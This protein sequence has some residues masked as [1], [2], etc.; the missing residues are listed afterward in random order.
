MLL[1]GWFVFAILQELI[2]EYQIEGIQGFRMSCHL[3]GYRCP[4]WA[5]M[6]LRPGPAI[7]QI[8]QMSKWAFGHVNHPKTSCADKVPPVWV[9]GDRFA[10]GGC[11]L[12]AH[13]LGCTFLMLSAYD[14]EELG[15]E[16]AGEVAASIACRLVSGLLSFFLIDLQEICLHALHWE[17]REEYGERFNVKTHHP[18]TDKWTEPYRRKGGCTEMSLEPNV[19]G[20]A[21]SFLRWWK[22]ID[23]RQWHRRGHTWDAACLGQLWSRSEDQARSKSTWTL[24]GDS[25]TP[26]SASW[27]CC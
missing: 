25:P 24:N 11:K 8:W 6:R 4:W 13:G 7:N 12:W 19:K 26:L 5:K 20:S 22:V 2:R 17:C 9:E 16:D 21:E 15:S 23:A 27:D 3:E 14:Q 1:D 18:L 10:G